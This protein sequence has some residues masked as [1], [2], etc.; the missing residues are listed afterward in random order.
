MPVNPLNITTLLT[1]FHHQY[2]IYKT[3]KSLHQGKLAKW[4]Q[5][6]IIVFR[7]P[8]FWHFTWDLF[9]HCLSQP[10][11]ASIFKWKTTSL[12]LLPPSGSW[13]CRWH[14]SIIRSHFA[15]FPIWPITRITWTRA[16]LN[17]INFCPR[18][19]NAK[20]EF[21]R[22]DLRPSLSRMCGSA[23]TDIW[24]PLER[25]RDH[26][27]WARSGAPVYLGP[28]PGNFEQFSPVPP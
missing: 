9:S 11:K 25:E 2:R 21:L 8:V 23:I 17:P 14:R 10:G 18:P 6:Q 15:I 28:S 4:K 13:F 1:P 20:T 24:S 5:N 3:Q 27:F 22:K 19:Q 12:W 26:L 7:H 16:D